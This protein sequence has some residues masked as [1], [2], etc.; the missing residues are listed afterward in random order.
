MSFPHIARW[1]ARSAC[2]HWARRYL[3]PSCAMAHPVN[4]KRCVTATR[5]CTRSGNTHFDPRL[6]RRRPRW[7]T[8]PINQRRSSAAC[9]RNRRT[10]ASLGAPCSSTAGHARSGRLSGLVSNVQRHKRM[11]HTLSHYRLAMPCPG[12]E[13]ASACGGCVVDTRRRCANCARPWIT[14]RRQ[15]MTSST[16]QPLPRCC[17][18]P[19][20][21]TSKRAS[22]RCRC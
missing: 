18:P 20:A 14:L 12:F 21:P 3:L 16:C 1:C 10:T 19:S 7:D 4:Q 17:P 11:R 6:A 8:P 22:S 15:S 9:A 2:H 5:C 13:S